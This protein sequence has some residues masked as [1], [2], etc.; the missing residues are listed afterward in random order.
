MKNSIIHY[1]GPGY[2]EGALRDLLSQRIA[3]VPAG[4][5]I[6][7][8]TYYFRDRKLARDLVDAGQRGVNVRITLDGRP[9]SI[10]ANDEV[11]Q[12]LKEGLGDGVRT[13]SS[14]KGRLHRG[15]LFRPRLH[16]KVYCFSHP[17]PVALVGS[18]NPS[19]DTP[20]QYPDVIKDIGD[21]DRAFN[22]L[23][24]L[25][26][27]KLVEALVDHCRS[28]HGDSYGFF[29]RF[30][31]IQNR[32]R[33]FGNFELHCWPRVSSDPVYALLKNSSPTSHVRIVASHFSG[34]TSLSTI[35]ATSRRG[36]KIELILESTERRV[37]QQVLSDLIEAGITIYS[38]DREGEW[39]PM[40]DKFM[41]V[42]DEGKK[43]CVFGSFNWNEPSRRLNRELGITSTE[44]LLFEQLEQRW[45]TLLKH[46]HKIVG[47]S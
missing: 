22:L 21:H 18:F 47:V 45:E 39:T 14:S 43:S 16:E 24:E 13:I 20:E 41:L 33:S 44:A 31:S 3:Q 30:R 27:P 4:G 5:S 12:I 9:R 17:E 26:E 15:K 6:D 46:Q 11:I 23:V 28:L 35:K 1:G 38:A 37:P 40:H 2:K 34:I 42:D 32:A 36:L 25:G 7:W 8:V 29:D 10:H 19:G